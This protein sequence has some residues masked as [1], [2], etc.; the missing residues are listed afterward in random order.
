MS[1]LFVFILSLFVFVVFLVGFVVYLETQMRDQMREST[2]QICR[3][4]R[5][6]LTQKLKEPEKASA[7]QPVFQPASAQTAAQL[8]TAAKTTAVPEMEVLEFLDFADEK[9]PNNSE[10][11]PEWNA[12]EVP[13]DWKTEKFAQKTVSSVE[14]PLPPPVPTVKSWE[15]SVNANSM[16]VSKG[17]NW[18]WF[19][20]E[21]LSPTDN[22]EFIAASNWLI[23]F[24]MLILVL[25]IGFF[26]KYSIDQGWIGPEMRILG[27]TFL[28]VVMYAAG[29]Y[30][31]RTS[32]NLLG[33]AL[34]AGSACVLYF[35]A[36]GASEL[37][38]LIPQWGGFS[39]GC[40]VTI[41]L[42]AS[43]IRW[44][45]RLIAVLGMLGAYVTPCLFPI[46]LGDP[47]GLAIYLA[48]PALGMLMIRRNKPWVLA[49]WIAFLGTLFLWNGAAD[50]ITCKNR[51][52]FLAAD[53][54]FLFCFQFV[55]QRRLRNLTIRPTMGD[56]L[57]SGLNFLF[58]G[59]ALLEISTYW[60]DSVLFGFC[61]GSFIGGTLGA[62]CAVFYAL[63]AQ[64]LK[65]T[66][67]N[68]MFRGLNCGLAL[69][70]VLISCGTGLEERWILPSM[71]IFAA[72]F[73]YV[74]HRL[75][76]N[77][78][79]W[80]AR[81]AAFVLCC[82]AVPVLI[83]SYAWSAETLFT[84]RAIDSFTVI[85]S[86]SHEFL[87]FQSETCFAFA[88]ERLFRFLT[89]GIALC[90]MGFHAFQER[91]NASLPMS[92]GAANF[93]ML[94]GLLHVLA[95][96][97]METNLLSYVYRPEMRLGAISIVWT[98]FALGLIG[99][100]IRG[101]FSAIRTGGLTLFAVTIFKIF[102]VDLS[103]LEQIYRIGAFIFLGL[104]ILTA[105]IIYLKSMKKP[106]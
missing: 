41:L 23:R 46:F 94:F 55:A 102:F 28:G 81:I 35:S 48:I 29:L 42:A 47:M 63:L 39:W 4:L 92:E 86:R 7:A 64:T 50:C 99:A 72:A 3:E 21:E 53:L 61:G 101:K 97:T 56:L 76:S 93:L 11:P 25:G 77:A 22:R 80:F 37:Y 27:T 34:L 38:E 15:P 84:H 14:E 98:L 2:E 85:S 24:G 32:L 96:L 49:A 20:R 105:G 6:V 90:F 104:L 70:C 89:P 62:V 5:N 17:W 82:V 100:G 73:Q 51:W 71:L 66:E 36:Y 9:T 16:E 40:G 31:W 18:F 78:S 45:S 19:G 33:Q 83:Y 74:S 26:V 44:D 8:V 43:A 65:H 91:K 106:A 79:A 58:F 1:F 88:W 52:T 30:F 95:Y 59:L 67:I 13:P 87:Y 54:F 69:I 12:A 75:P 10:V 60:E 103:A 68:Q 57:L